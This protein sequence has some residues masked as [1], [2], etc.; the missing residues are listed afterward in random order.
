MATVGAVAPSRTIV[1]ST[2]AA[3]GLTV[4]VAGPAAATTATAR[5]AATAAPTAYVLNTK[6][7]TVTPID[8]ATNTAGKPIK[9]GPPYGVENIVF[10][11]DGKTAYIGDSRGVIPMSTAT[12]KLGKPIPAPGGGNLY[13]T[14]NGKTVYDVVIHGEVV[15]ITTATHTA[16]KPI[17]LP[18]LEEAAAMA[19]DGKTLYAAIPQQNEIVPV[20]TATNR[21]G[22]P[23]SLA[24]PSDMVITPD[25]HT[26]YVARS[27]VAGASSVVT[28]INLVTGKV[29]R[30]INIG[31][32]VSNYLVVSPDGHTVYVFAENEVVPISTATNTVGKPIKIK[33]VPTGFAFSPSGK[34][35]YVAST[36]T[37][38]APYQ[39]WVTPITLATHT[40]GVPVKT[41][42]NTY[43]LAVT[44]DG[45]TVYAVN[46]SSNSVTPIA[47]A[48]GTAGAPLK[49]G[50]QPDGIAITP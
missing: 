6:S 43:S 26:M 13:I 50:M 1:V 21:A 40:A 22:T 35:A 12:N 30:S 42:L 19:P 5:A 7:G 39:S 25:S 16:G 36:D 45:K 11:P 44:P 49:V 23:I 9:A 14:P 29:G 17:P 15:P 28:P 4:A 18:G 47:T 33:D 24:S 10:A 27:P 46:F 37:Q 8:T 48:T 31:S 32:D 34:T 3:L 38:T 20:N 2:I 41:G